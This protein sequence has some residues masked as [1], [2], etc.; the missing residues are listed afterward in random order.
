MQ[1]W[2]ELVGAHDGPGHQ[3]REERHVE[4]V[5]EHVD[6]GQDAAP[7]DVHQIADALEGEERYADGQQDVVDAE[8]RRAAQQVAGHGHIVDH[9]DGDAEKVVEHRRKKIGVL[10]IKEHGEARN[11]AGAQPERAPAPGRAVDEPPEDVGHGHRRYQDER[12]KSARLVIEKDAD[13][14]QERIAHQ[15]FVAHQTEDGEHR[16]KECPEVELREEQRRVRVECKRVFQKIDQHYC[17][18]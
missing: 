6:H 11:D 18:S 15:H 4:T 9:L 12:E 8:A 5:V 14:E 17:S 10:I 13:K 3:L 7:V 2:H 16:G 1:L